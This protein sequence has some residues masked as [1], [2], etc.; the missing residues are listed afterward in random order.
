MHGTLALHILSQIS[1]IERSGCVNIQITGKVPRFRAGIE[2]EI[3]GSHA[4]ICLSQQDFQLS[5]NRPLFV[6]LMAVTQ[7]NLRVSCSACADAG[8]TEGVC[9]SFEVGHSAAQE[10][11]KHRLRSS[12]THL[13]TLIN[14]HGNIAEIF[15]AETEVQQT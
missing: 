13:N 11:V 10:E 15:D 7:R 3:L 8:E 9:P 14:A 2:V 12:H 6:Q 1:G 4:G 5:T